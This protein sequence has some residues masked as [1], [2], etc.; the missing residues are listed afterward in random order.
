MWSKLSLNG[1]RVVIFS[2]KM[3]GVPVPPESPPMKR[4][5]GKVIRYD[6]VYVSEVA[7]NQNGY[8]RR[9]LIFDII[10]IFFRYLLFFINLF[11]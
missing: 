4:G 9:I 1:H 3:W 11:F 10:L 5:G 8:L 2:L 7:D 6:S